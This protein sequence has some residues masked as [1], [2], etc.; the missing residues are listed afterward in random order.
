MRLHCSLLLTDFPRIV[1][2]EEEEPYSGIA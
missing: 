2:K 1:R